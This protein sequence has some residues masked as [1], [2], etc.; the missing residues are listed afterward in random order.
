MVNF[1]YIG[2]LL[3]AF[4]ALPQTIM[5]IIEGNARGISHLFLLSWYLGEILMLVYCLHIGL[6]GPLL[7]NYLANVAMLT[8]ITR[9]K[10]F[11]R[12]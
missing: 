5:C 8:I 4:C 6:R 7:Y 10:Y 12:K 11:E 2:A 3:L 9:Y 1:G